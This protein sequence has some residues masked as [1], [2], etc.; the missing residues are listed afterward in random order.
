MA[1]CNCLGSVL[2]QLDLSCLF[3][4]VGTCAGF[5]FGLMLNS[6]TATILR[7]RY[8]FQLMPR[9][10]GGIGYYT[11]APIGSDTTRFWPAVLTAAVAVVLSAQLVAANG[12]QFGSLLMWSVLLAMSQLMPVGWR[13]MSLQASGVTL[14]L[15]NLCES[16]FVFTLVGHLAK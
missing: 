4:P 7:Y 12:W 5:L 8:L 11:Y 9:A 6:A 3:F 1:M 16:Y 10:S 15:A 2:V 14:L 13:P